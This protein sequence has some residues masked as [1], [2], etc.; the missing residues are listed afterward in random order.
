MDWFVII[1]YFAIKNLKSIL[2]KY[3]MTHEKF[4]THFGLFLIN[5]FV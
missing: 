4:N 2:D 5:L 3:P 1:F